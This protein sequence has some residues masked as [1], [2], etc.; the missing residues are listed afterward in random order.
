MLIQQQW[1]NCCT[2]QCVH[3]IFPSPPLKSWY[4]FPCPHNHQHDYEFPLNNFGTCLQKGKSPILS[5]KVA[6]NQCKNKRIK[7]HG[8]T[9]PRKEKNSIFTQNSFFDKLK[10]HLNQVKI[11]KNDFSIH[12]HLNFWSKMMIKYDIFRNPTSFSPS[13]LR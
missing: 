3:A 4:P 9:N 7:V 10:I 12:V 8:T 1:G 5:S 2:K 6:M 11:T 13:Y